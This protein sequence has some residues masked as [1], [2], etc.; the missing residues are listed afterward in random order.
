MTFSR[1]PSFRSMLDPRFVFRPDVLC[2]AV[3]RKFSS[4]HGLVVAATAWGDALEF[5]PSKHI[6][7]QIYLRGVFEL[8][9][10]ETLARLLDAGDEAFDVGA[11]IGL[12]SSLM[13][14]SV[15]PAGKVAAIEAHPE[16]FARLEANI[17]RWRRDNVRALHIAVSRSAGDLSIVDEGEGMNNEGVAHVVEGAAISS[18][19]RVFTVPSV[20]IDD[21]LDGRSLG[22]MKVDV[23]GH[24]L[25]VFEGAASSLKRRSIRDIVFEA[26]ISDQSPVHRL[27]AGFGYHVF[28]LEQGFFRPQLVPIG[29][30][31]SSSEALGDFL[32]TTQPDR[33]LRRM[34]P[35]GWR[36]LWGGITSS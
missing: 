20:T 13:S 26:P 33:A 35:G 27:L 25:A 29:R 9:V 21:M 36:V 4:H 14:K 18:S 16:V 22:A 12:M 15:G 24:E 5:D 7:S 11:N 1:L 19:Q 3:F 23:E 28:R 17:R 30:S 32:A 31:P 8:H 2:R 6:G 10:C 34:A